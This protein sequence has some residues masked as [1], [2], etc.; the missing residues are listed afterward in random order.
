MCS[1]YH[2]KVIQLSRKASAHLYIAVTLK[3]TFLIPYR[4]T[5]SVLWCC[6]AG[7]GC[8]CPAEDSLVHPNTVGLRE[9]GMG[10]EVGQLRAN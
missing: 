2:E 6:W 7:Q 3:V 5:A 10:E 1:K 9:M 8:Q 4:G